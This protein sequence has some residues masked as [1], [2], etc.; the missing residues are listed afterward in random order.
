MLEQTA[1]YKCV[2]FLQGV[3]DDQRVHQLD[4]SSTWCMGN[5]SLTQLIVHPFHWDG[6]DL[7]N[8]IV[9]VKLDEVRVEWEYGDSMV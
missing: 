3:Y 2:I 9:L 8:K 5:I 6:T 7:D 4:L 1:K